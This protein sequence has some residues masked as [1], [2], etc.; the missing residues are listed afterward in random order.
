MDPLCLANHCNQPPPVGDP[1]ICS[2]ATYR[3]KLRCPPWFFNDSKCVAAIQHAGLPPHACQ[4]YCDV[5]HGTPVYMGG[6]HPR[7]KRPVGERLA[8]AA[9]NLVYGGTKAHTRGFP[10]CC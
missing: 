10:E 1:L 7:I 4:T 3:G 8:T 5:L 2:N 6:I 9:Y